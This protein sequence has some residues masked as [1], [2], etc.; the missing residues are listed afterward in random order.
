LAGVLDFDAVVGGVVVGSCAADAACRHLAKGWAG[1][2]LGTIL[3]F[4]SDEVGVVVLDEVG[5]GVVVAGVGDEFG[6]VVLNE[7]G[8]ASSMT[9]LPA[10][11]M[12]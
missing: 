5:S 9:S 12:R 8:A 4:I 3:V 6:V 7:V 1:G 2:V 10:S 11:A